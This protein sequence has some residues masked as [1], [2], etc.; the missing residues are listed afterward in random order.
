MSVFN[1]FILKGINGFSNEYRIMPIM[2]K[3]KQSDF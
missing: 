3:S 2:F 1:N